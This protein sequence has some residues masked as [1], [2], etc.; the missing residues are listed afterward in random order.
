MARREAE[1]LASL[2]YASSQFRAVHLERMVVQPNSVLKM[3]PRK[4]NKMS[5]HREHTHGTRE[6]N[7]EK[8]ND[9]AFA[10]EQE[11]S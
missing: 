8:L 1:S 11:N 7:Y 3:V 9:V 10:M 4:E 5:V 6:N 2:K